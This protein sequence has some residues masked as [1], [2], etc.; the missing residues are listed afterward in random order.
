M[1]R[2]TRIVHATLAPRDLN[3]DAPAELALIGDAG[4]TLQALVAEVKDRLRGGPRGRAGA[5]AQEIK[6]LKT[7]WLS[8][9]MPRLTSNAKPLSP[10]R[11]PWDLI[12]TVDVSR[13]IITHDAVSPRDQIAPFCEPVTP[14]THIDWGQTTPRGT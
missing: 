9:W 10:Y 5:V 4:L 1:P 13:T 14:L 8:Q 3:K 12:H 11:G 6:T 7:E 2:R